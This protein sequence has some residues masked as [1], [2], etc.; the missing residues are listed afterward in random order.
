MN[1]FQPFNIYPRELTDIEMKTLLLMLP[2][3]K[4]GYNSYRGK[5]KKSF[6]IG[7]GRFGKG[8]YFLGDKGNRH[9][10][11]VSSS[12]VLAA[13]VVEFE[14]APVD[15]SIHEEFEDKIEIDLKPQLET[16]KLDS[17]QPK[18]Y[19]TYSEWVPGKKAP[20]DNSTLREVHLIKNF[21]VI[22]IVPTHKRVWI[23]EAESEINH[24]IPVTNF[25]NEIMRVKGERD[26][27]IVL[28]PN[29]LFTH[30]NELTDQE[31]GQGFFLYNKYLNKI[32][33]DYS[34]FKNINKKKQKT[35]FRIFNRSKN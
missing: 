3:N 33:L 1:N 32:K 24:L 13:G 30:H 29:R 27:E 5:I 14:E 20:G 17:T 22:A 19:W 8:N 23:Y 26:P 25:Y 12:P 4:S 10:L 28:K 2:E 18:H 35:F 16:K 9:D 31:I 11:T 15:V 21:L 6:V 7:E 34:L